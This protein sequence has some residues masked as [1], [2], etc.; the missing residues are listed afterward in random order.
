MSITKSTILC[1]VICDTCGT[2]LEDKKYFA[3]DIGKAI[4]QGIGYCSVECWVNRD[5]KY[6]ILLGK[7]R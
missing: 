3:T 5:N 6:R 7:I 4:T 1:P 2:Y